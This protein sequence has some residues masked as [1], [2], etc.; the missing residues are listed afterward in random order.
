[1]NDRYTGMG[2]VVLLCILLVTVSVLSLG[3]TET[4]QTGDTG[5]DASVSVSKEIFT[6][7]DT[8]LSVRVNAGDLVQVELLEN[9][10][11]GYSWD[12]SATDGL[13]LQDDQY[14]VYEHEE[15]MAGVG[16]VHTWT[17]EAQNHGE[18]V[19]SGIYK[20]SWENETGDEQTFDLIVTVIPA[21]ED[22]DE[23]E[24]NEN[25]KDVEDLEYVYDDAMVEDVQVLVMES[26]PVQVSAVASGYVPDG[27][28]EIDEDNITVQRVGNVFDITL[29]TM[30]PRDAMCTQAIE[31]FEVAIPLDV[32]GLEKGVYMVDVNGVNATFEL[33][34]DNVLE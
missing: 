15:G 6:G 30:R 2:T 5:E 13:V 16:G 18:Q 9:P 31:P 33:Q 23:G 22:R 32:Y 20:R 28:T 25:G 29:R 10:T 21:G 8:G 12:L 1:M 4:S 26:F 7:N 27:C 19:I 34:T 11:T 3:C 17:F 14:V 24:N